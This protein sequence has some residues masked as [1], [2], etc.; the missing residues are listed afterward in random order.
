ME[1]V[2]FQKNYPLVV[3]TGPTA[4]GKTSLAIELAAQYGGE[5]ICADSRTVYRG[6]DIGTAKPTKVEQ[7]E[8]K[9]WGLD[10]VDPGGKFTVVD[11]Q[12]YA[13]SKID[14]IR[15]S[16]KIPFLVGGTGLYI[17]SVVLDYQ[18]PKHSADNRSKYNSWTVD[19]LN[20]YCL[21]NNIQLP[22]NNLNKRHLINAISRNNKPGR[23]REVPV[24]NCVVVGISTEKSQ[25]NQRI[26]DR[27]NQIFSSKFLEEAQILSEKYGWDNEAMTGNIYPLARGILEK[28]IT[29]D[30]ARTRFI[31]LDRRLAKRQ[32]TW[33][34]SKSY[35]TWKT[36]PEARKYLARLLDST[37]NVV[38]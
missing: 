24:K 12:K 17:D 18:F 13:K 2:I 19:Q 32:L 27:T 34:R 26:E 16:N 38:L 6:M 29:I 4:S 37:S 28:K 14:E 21:D 30:D 25:L 22:L 5:I 1:K 9:H 7:A 33:M 36:L 11:F 20:Q 23:K 10:L 31:T 15:I 3:I 35:I 8:V